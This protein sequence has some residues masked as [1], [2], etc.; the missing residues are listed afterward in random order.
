MF[1]ISVE[2]FVVICLHQGLIPLGFYD[3]QLLL[4]AFDILSKFELIHLL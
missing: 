1:V 2:I 4:V 3:F